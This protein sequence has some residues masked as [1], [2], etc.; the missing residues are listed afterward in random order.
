MLSTILLRKS[1]FVL[2]GALGLSVILCC[3]SL[4]LLSYNEQQSK[5]EVDEIHSVRHGEVLKR[6]TQAAQRTLTSN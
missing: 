6:A 4:E 1:T 5:K 2:M 3:L